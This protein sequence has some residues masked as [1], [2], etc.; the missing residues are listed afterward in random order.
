MAYAH[1]HLILQSMESSEEEGEEEKERLR[2]AVV[3]SA[4]LQDSV[5]TT[6]KSAAER[7]EKV[8]RA[9]VYLTLIAHARAGER[10][11]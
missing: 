3:T 8:G 4:Q 9:C 2:C 6:I 10:G 1:V 7:Y 11:I 5:R